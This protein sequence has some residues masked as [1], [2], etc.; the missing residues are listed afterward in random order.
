MFDSKSKMIIF[1]ISLMF[2]IGGS[3][4]TYSIFGVIPILGLC[5]IIYNAGDIIHEQ[6]K[7]I[8]RL[9]KEALH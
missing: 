7:E 3:F 1:G 9:K 4:M 8:E 5:W 6:K 2:C